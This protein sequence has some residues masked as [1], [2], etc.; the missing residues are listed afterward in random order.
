MK[1]DTGER[2]VDTY[3]KVSIPSSCLAGRLHAVRNV[4]FIFSQSSELS[5]GAWAEQLD[6][7][8]EI[9][10]LCKSHTESARNP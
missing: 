1:T 5:F 6:F 7:K 3:L 4:A 9:R 10:E 2:Y 8:P